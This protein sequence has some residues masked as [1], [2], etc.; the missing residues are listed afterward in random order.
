MASS[1]KPKRSKLGAGEHQIR[2]CV[3]CRGRAKK[4]A[5]IRLVLEESESGG[6]LI[7]LD[8]RGNSQKRGAYVHRELKCILGLR[9]IKRIRR[10]FCGNGSGA[11]DIELPGDIT[12]D[13]VMIESLCRGL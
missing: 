11:A 4:N 13:P 1:K 7:A 5:L 3:V 12:I 2:Q 9:G 6:H 10:F 8:L